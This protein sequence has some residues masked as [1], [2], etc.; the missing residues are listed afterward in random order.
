MTA[1][2]KPAHHL[3]RPPLGVVLPVVLQEDEVELA[4]LREPRQ[5]GPHLVP[6]E[7][8]RKAHTIEPIRGQ[9]VNCER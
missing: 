5:S 9:H 1:V 8:V 6:E 7:Q 4:Q 2:R 3:R